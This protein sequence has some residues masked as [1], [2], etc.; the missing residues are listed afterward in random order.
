M[1]RE[2]DDDDEEDD[3]VKPQH[4][5]PFLS[6]SL[7]DLRF[8]TSLKQTKTLV[9]T[10]GTAGTAAAAAKQLLDVAL[11]LVMLAGAGGM[12]TLLLLD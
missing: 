4:L 11:L 10:D 2:K 1:T 7:P 12:M 3:E 6:H 8:M 9:M 5:L